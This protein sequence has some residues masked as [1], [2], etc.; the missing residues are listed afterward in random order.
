[1]TEKPLGDNCS[2]DIECLVAN[3]ECSTTCQC[4]TEYYD[5]NNDASG[6]SCEPC[7]YFLCIM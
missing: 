6:G 3:S 2:A 1:M 4:Q 5:T 7:K